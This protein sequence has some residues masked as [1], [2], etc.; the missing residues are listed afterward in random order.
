MDLIEHLRE[1]AAW[2]AETFG[3]GDRL[4]GV[5]DHMT[6]EIEEVREAAPEDRLAEWVDLI[7]LA[8]DGAWRSGASPE[9]IAAA[10]RAKFAKNRARQWPDWRTADPTKA[11]EHVAGIHD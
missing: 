1:Q 2:S 3:P 5:T 9:D 4:H 8:C 11:I 10:I 7:I 6:K